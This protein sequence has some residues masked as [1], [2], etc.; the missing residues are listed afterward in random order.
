M[1]KTANCRDLREGCLQGRQVLTQVKACWNVLHEIVVS[2]SQSQTQPL[3]HHP[4]I[5]CEE[6]TH[7]KRPW[8]WEIL[9]AGG[10]G[11]DRGWDGW[12]ASLTRWTWVWASSGS[13]WWAGKP[14][15][16]QSM[17]V[18]KTQTQL[19]DWIELNWTNHW[20]TS[21]IKVSDTI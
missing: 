15:M 8:C 19:S 4:F 12:M 2:I 10:E 1:K 7:W 13:W 20:Q 3:I 14:D 21:L 5:W 11:A 18:T 9:K 17:G 6:L 16:L